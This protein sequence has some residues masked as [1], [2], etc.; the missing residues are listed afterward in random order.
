[1]EQCYKL[2][3]FLIHAYLSLDQLDFG[4]RAWHRHEKAQFAAV[5]IGGHEGLTFLDAVPTCE[6]QFKFSG[7]PGHIDRI[8]FGE[9]EGLTLQLLLQKPERAQAEQVGFCFYYSADGT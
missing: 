8:A 9:H 6:G 1:M 4:L 3:Y 2:I 7:G 5:V